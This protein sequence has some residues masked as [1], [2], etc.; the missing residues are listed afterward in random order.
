MKGTWI[1]KYH[2][3]HCLIR[4]YRY[5]FPYSMHET[6]NDFQHTKKS[7]SYCFGI[8]ITSY[9]RLS[10]ARKLSC[11]HFYVFW[12][13]SKQIR[14]SET[15]KRKMGTRKNMCENVHV[16]MQNKKKT[17]RITNHRNGCKSWMPM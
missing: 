14:A 8:F 17:N 6:M 7:V 13:L 16:Q 3:L 15:R 11:V 12:S 5:K 4:I 2:V 1:C 9:C 10:R